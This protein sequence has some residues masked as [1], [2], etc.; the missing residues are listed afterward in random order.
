[1][2][3]VLIVSTLV[4][5]ML[6]AFA[7]HAQVPLPGAIKRFWP[8]GDTN[9]VSADEQKQP[10]AVF[11]NYAQQW[12]ENGVTV[13]LLHGGCRVTQGDESLEANQ[14]V[15]W[16]GQQTFK[17]ATEDQVAVY[18]EGDARIVRPDGSRPQQF[19]A[20]E[21]TTRGGT[22][23]IGRPPHEGQP[24]SHDPLYQRASER[25]QFEHSTLITLA[26][27]QVPDLRGSGDDESLVYSQLT[28][29]QPSLPSLPM[30]RHVSIGPRYL[31]V[32]FIVD[33][34]L[35]NSTPPEW[36]I[37]IKQGV[38]I[39]VEG[40]P[41]LIDGVMQPGIIDLTADRAV[42][43]TDPDK[44]QDLSFGF[45]LDSGTKMQVYLEGNI[46]VRQGDNVLRASNAYYDLQTERGLLFNAELRTFIPE[47]EG[48]LRVRATRVRQL[49]RDNFH[50][51]NAWVSASQFGKPGYRLESSDIFLE[52]RPGNPYP[53]IAQNPNDPNGGSAMWVTSLNNRF[54]I[55]DVP[56]FATPFLSAPAEDPQIPIRDARF[57]Q[58]R[59]FGTQIGIT[60]NAE[61]LFGLDLPP[62]TDVSLITDYLSDR[63]PAIGGTAEYIG[64]TEMFGM[65]T[66]YNGMA[67]LYYV[68]DGGRDN[69]GL[70]R[71]SLPIDGVNRDKSRG[72]T[73]SACR[74]TIGSNPRS[75]IS[76]IATIWNSSTKTTGTR[77]RTTKPTSSSAS[78]STT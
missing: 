48:D 36:V 24:Q 28:P 3:G 33:T 71:R 67:D 1:M 63:G 55:D 49:S 76:A 11:A 59:I 53:W 45:D 62:N 31:D 52:R 73:V 42:I 25:T 61:A 47:L 74:A 23:F 68:N 30:R 18:A 58:D 34:E 43:Y 50:A 60:W 10:I 26:N 75:A 56:I 20:A 54:L 5:G 27:A 12:D 4:A 70:D 22:H 32:P 46:V 78:R 44:V 2:T 6:C 38:N 57:D 37:K 40:V 41:V 8:G 39:V 69:L 13:L 17:G 29:F 19:V 72:G 14:M 7:A 64:A 9:A 35:S 77:A 66:L 15:L 16:L 21:L 65:P 51:Q